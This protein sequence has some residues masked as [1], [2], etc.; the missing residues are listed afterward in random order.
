M[1]LQK[2]GNTDQRLTAMLG[3]A[4]RW[5]SGRAKHDTAEWSLGGTLGYLG[6]YGLLGAALCVFVLGGWKYALVAAALG[7]ASV[8]GGMVIPV[9]DRIYRIRRYVP[10][11]FAG[12]MD[13]IVGYLNDR[14]DSAERAIVGEGA[15]MYNVLARLEAQ[16]QEAM[17][18]VTAFTDRNIATKLDEAK[19]LHERI[20]AKLDELRAHRDAARQFFAAVRQQIADLLRDDAP[21]ALEV[22]LARLRTGVAEST[23]EA[24]RIIADNVTLIAQTL[25]VAQHEL[26]ELIAQ[27][28]VAA[29][30]ALPSVGDGLADFQ[31][32][33]A[34]VG[35]YLEGAR[36]IDFTKLLQGGAP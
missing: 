34:V 10:Q 7:A 28:G 6:S 2:L 32:V 14:I 23:A 21:A 30:G 33:D 1:V 24:D 11:K 16:Q 25:T 3:T 15:P 36:A 19:A 18:L 8:C 9:V 27:T 29:A 5:A 20:T 26:Q 4:R 17:V 13:L 12:D 22:R 35:A 31:Q